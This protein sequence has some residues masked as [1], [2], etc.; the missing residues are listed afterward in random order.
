MAT[1][2]S[3]PIDKGEFVADIDE[4]AEAETTLRYNFGYYKDHLTA[5]NPVGE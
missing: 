5:S 1:V 2:I 4:F 3:Q